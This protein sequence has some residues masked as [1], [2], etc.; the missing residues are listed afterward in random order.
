MRVRDKGK[1]ASQAT[2]KRFL[3]IVP[4]SGSDVYDFDQQDA[5]L[6]NSASSKSKK[7]TDE[8]RS[9]MHIKSHAGASKKH[10]KN[11]ILYSTDAVIEASQSGKTSTP[12]PV[13]GHQK[14]K[15]KTPGTP[16][17]WVVLSRL[18]QD[19]F[20][21]YAV[22]PIAVE[23]HSPNDL[24]RQI[25]VNSMFDDTSV[26]DDSAISIPM[27][28]SDNV[29]SDSRDKI[30]VV[31]SDNLIACG[32]MEC[33]D[34]QEYY[35]QTSDKHKSDTDS[36]YPKSDSQSEFVNLSGGNNIEIAT[37]RSDA[38]PDE[39]GKV[40][41]LML[42]DVG[43]SEDDRNVTFAAKQALVENSENRLSDCEVIMY[44]LGRL[45]VEKF[46]SSAARNPCKFP[47]K[48]HHGM[49]D[50]EPSS[51]DDSDGSSFSIVKAGG[52]L[53][54]LVEDATS[55]HRNP[56][57]ALKVRNA[58]IDSNSASALSADSEPSTKCSR[59]TDRKTELA[60]TS[61]GKSL[62][63]KELHNTADLENADIHEKLTS[64][65]KPRKKQN[66]NGGS[67]KQ[68]SRIRKAGAS[69]PDLQDGDSNSK[70]IIVSC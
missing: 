10:V 70:R 20:A 58:G 51:S 36:G 67:K 48:R 11:K 3:Q 13:T 33:I 59:K 46:T 56:P 31:S 42:H 49:D 21:A 66:T 62:Q 40:D 15:K 47:S 23:H 4:E 53:N 28:K 43:D 65:D 52:K 61:T 16:A 69:G 5:S 14:T 39:L 6:M 19:S 26:M 25:D 34:S 35:S 45:D 18:Q 54:Q 12:C 55:Q 44:K 7:L 9:P 29:G 68:T 41:L 17:P 30:S 60:E 22:S 24:S 38:D 57:R 64:R 2:K 32:L 37:G 63:V 27:S 50:V 8:F 1:G